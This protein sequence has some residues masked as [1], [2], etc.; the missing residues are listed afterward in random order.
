[1][2]DSFPHLFSPIAIGAYTLKNRIM[3]TG[4]AAHFQTGDGIPTGRYVDY[5]GERA[6]GGV[7]IVVTGHTVPYYDGDVALSLASYDDRIVPM[8]QRMAAATHA[9]EAPLLAQLGHRGRRVADGAAFL[10]RPSMAPSAVP[11]PDFSA[12]QLVPHAMT[13]AEIEETLEQFAAAARRAM[14]GD[15]DGIELAVGMD[16][17]FPNFLNA[18]SNRREDRYGGATL[19]ERM[20]FL[21]ETVDTVRDAIGR[22]R[23]LGIRMYD[24]LEEWGLRL[25]DYR[26]VARRLEAH[27]KVDYFNM[28]QGIVPSPRSGRAH[29]PAHY[30][31]PGAFAHLPRGI[32]EH[33]SLP[34]VGTGRLDSPAVAERFIADGT[35]DLVG[36]ARALIAD[37]HLPNKAREGRT[38]DI[39]TCI[40]CTQSCVGHIYV[41]MGV[42]CIYNPVTGREGEWAVLPPAA[43]RRKVVVVGWR[44]GWPGSRT[45]RG[46]ARARGRAVRA[47]GPSRRPGEP[48]DA[49]PGA[50]QL[51]G[52]HPLLRAPARQARSRRAAPHRGGGRRHV[53]A[54]SP[55]AVVVATGSNAFRPEV[56]GNDK[57]HVLTAREV[58]Q[59]NAPIGESVLVVDT[60]GRAEAPTVAELLADMGRKVEIVTGLAYVGCE[61]PIPAWH[62]LMERLLRKN[63]TLTPFTGV[64]EIEDG[65]VD[66][67]NVIS[68][69]PRTME[70]I[71]TVVFAS[72]GVPEDALGTALADA[73]ADAVAEVHVIG[74]CY[75]PRD[76]EIAVVDGHRAGR[77][78]GAEAS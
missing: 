15:L 74:D 33:V 69:Q 59:G 4:H 58:I 72:G 32:K 48:R 24:D 44:A 63:V 60:L 66:A 35:A 52:D 1:M 21:N 38:G 28:W 10:G 45:H 78:I 16:Y 31:P 56:I 41:G 61:M 13:I 75:Q 40:A 25:D 39:R 17:L 46:R 51:R 64:W 6:K 7:G 2:S 77:A 26:Q 43:K 14:A 47:R 8:Y 53:L 65:S 71:D 36:M 11:A 37:P 30:Y 23:I 76:I 54:E 68:W 5:V 22:E 62:N 57:R 12:P 18:Q 50:R 3:N 70:G 20:T 73:V 55:D 34:V 42:G 67:Y 49:D 29:W 9:Y 27:G 19:E